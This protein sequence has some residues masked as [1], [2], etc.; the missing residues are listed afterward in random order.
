MIT[1]NKFNGHELFNLGCNDPIKT[2]HL[3]DFIG[4]FFDKN[5]TFKNVDVNYE[6]KYTHADLNKARKM[7]GY[8]PTINFETG[9][10]RFLEWFKKYEN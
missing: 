7:L 10:S 3:L 1:K 4:R 9:M 2:S 5:Y 6:S 8:N